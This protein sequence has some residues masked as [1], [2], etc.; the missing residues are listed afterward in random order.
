MIIQKLEIAESTGATSV[1]DTFGNTL[2][3]EMRY[4]FTTNLIFKKV[5]PDVGSV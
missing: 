3:V 2:V 4:F 5:R 1:H